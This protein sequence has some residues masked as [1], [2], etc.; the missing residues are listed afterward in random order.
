M[1]IKW[2]RH[3]RLKGLWSLLGPRV[4]PT[5]RGLQRQLTPTPTPKS[6][7]FL[8]LS[9]KYDKPFSSSLYISS[10]SFPDIFASPV[11]YTVPS[12]YEQ[13]NKYLFNEWMKGWVD[14]WTNGQMD[15]WMDKRMEGLSCASLWNEGII[16]ALFMSILF[17][18]KMMTWYTYTE[19]NDY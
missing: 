18:I 10:Q 16:S 11:H 17:L 19:W 9:T 4:P 15:G 14:G 2:K 8:L 13:F 1:N 6:V 7:A 3:R 12:T 5:G